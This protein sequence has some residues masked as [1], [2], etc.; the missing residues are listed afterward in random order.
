MTKLK[1][2][3]RRTSISQNQ[4]TNLFLSAAAGGIVGLSAALLMAPKSG[5]KLRNDIYETYEDLTERGQDLAHDI[6]HKGKRAAH[7]AACYA[8]DLKD[9]AS[10]LLERESTTNRNIMIGVIGGGLL[11]AAAV[12]LMNQNSDDEESL[13]H[14]LR[15]AG[16]SAKE[17]IQSMDWVDT[18]KEIL[19]TIN[20]KVNPLHNG[21]ISEAVEDFQ[22][23]HGLQDVLKWAN[24]GLNLWQNVKKRR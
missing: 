10:S 2:M 18:A 16:R 19:E 13:S 6:A 5:Q 4:I 22:E 7:A 12:L 21:S 17:N 1:S 8:E 9:S 23:R 14:R 11:G 20:N 3:E 15:E 24:M